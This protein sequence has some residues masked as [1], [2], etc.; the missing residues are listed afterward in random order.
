MQC[1]FNGKYDH[2]DYFRPRHV[3]VEVRNLALYEGM[4]R[5]FCKEQ[6]TRHSCKDMPAYTCGLSKTKCFVCFF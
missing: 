2:E 3:D 6:A 5:L 1:T 4:D